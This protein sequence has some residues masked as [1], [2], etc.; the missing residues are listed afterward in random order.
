MEIDS[1]C[2][3]FVARRDGW[4]RP[5]PLG[6]PRP[7]SFVCLLN[8]LFNIFCVS[9][10]RYDCPVIFTVLALWQS[11]STN[12][13]HRTLSLIISSHLVKGRLVVMIMARVPVRM[14]I[15]LKSSSAPSLSNPTYPISS[16]MTR[17]YFLKRF[18][19]C[20]SVLSVLATRISVSRCGTV[21]KKTLY[22]SIHA[23][24]PSPM[25]MCVFLVLGLPY[26]TKLRPSR[27]NSRVSTSGRIPRRQSGSSSLTSSWR[28]FI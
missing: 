10:T 18:S 15:I 22:P 6:V 20:C 24:I 13:E 28:Y 16:Q 12:A 25:A 27:M 8:L 26:I 1:S 4:S 9:L 17:S 2:S 5:L 11:L 14:Y 3:N 23:F 19:N 7:M 21:V